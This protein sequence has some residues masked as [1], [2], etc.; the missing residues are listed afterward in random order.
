[1]LNN[2][3]LYLEGLKDILDKNCYVVVS[4]KNDKHTDSE[5]IV[6]EVRKL[7]NAEVILR[8][9]DYSKNIVNALNYLSNRIRFISNSIFLKETNLDK[10][11]G[12]NY[13]LNLYK[14]GENVFMSSICIATNGQYIPIAS[15]IAKNLEVA[16]CLLNESKIYKPQIDI[17][18]NYEVKQISTVES[19]YG[20]ISL[21]PEERHYYKV[22][23]VVPKGIN[24]FVFDEQSDC[25]ILPEFG[26]YMGS[27]N[28]WSINFV[29]KKFNEEFP[30]YEIFIGPG[31]SYSS[32]IK[33][34]DGALGIYCGNYK[35]ILSGKKIKKKS[36]KSN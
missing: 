24:G 10:N 5:K 16:I 26:A 34:S 27:Y 22:S 19:K 25:W 2:T 35:E 7:E 6:V 4:K 31:V 20:F 36:K 28:S 32:D 8:H 21:T 18:E 1:M 13:T 23:G 17:H 14:V 12:E 3:D 33:V 11:V 15:E 29:Q 9:N 30:D